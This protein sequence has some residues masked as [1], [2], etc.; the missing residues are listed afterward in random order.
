[1]SHSLRVRAMRWPSADAARIGDADVK[2][3]TASLLADA[4]L[5]ARAVGMLSR[6]ERARYSGYGNEVVARRFAVGRAML[7]EMLGALQSRL[8]SAV[9][10]VEGQFGKPAL[11]RDPTNDPLHFSVAH[12]DDLLLVALSREGDVGVD[13]E[14]TRPIDCWERVAD[15]TL[16]PAERSQLLRA[17]ERGEHAD[18]VFLRHWCRVEAELKAIGCGIHGIE[19][20]RAGE[21]PKGLRVADL[22]N[23]PLP[24]DLAGA[25]RYQ[26]AVALCAPSESA[27]HAARAASQQ[28]S[29]SAAPA[30]ASTP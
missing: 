8:P 14:R 4:S 11:A 13:V 22:A 21:R 9:R 7:R 19:A 2:V 12:C 1:M 29:P 10:L 3:Y 26:A 16:A 6:A 18:Q 20:H 23:L 17:V 27:R 25:T 5:L 24:P 15:R 28:S 30:R